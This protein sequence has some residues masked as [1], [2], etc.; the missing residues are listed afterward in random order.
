MAEEYLYEAELV[1]F[2]ERH[3]AV[4]YL[5]GDVTVLSGAGS[6]GW[7]CLAMTV[8]FQI[9]GGAV[10]VILADGREYRVADG[11]AF[12]LP[13]GLEHKIDRVSSGRLVSRWGDFRLVIFGRSDWVSQPALFSGRSAKRLGEIC[14]ALSEKPMDATELVTAAAQRKRWEFELLELIGARCV[15]AADLSADVAA[16]RRIGPALELM[17]QQMA[18]NLTLADLAGAVYL[19]PSRF[20]ALFHKALGV[21][22]LAHLQQ[23][24]LERACGLLLSSDLN[25][26]EVGH[27]VGYGDQFHFSRLFKRSYELSPQAYRKRWWGGLWGAIG[28]KKQ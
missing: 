27:A 17:R 3:L 16:L 25:I 5:G 6:T 4:E 15:V 28:E 24:R 23:M 22:P 21:A 26:A 10:E 18:A 20:H 19:S 2:V 9:T 8:C 12:V 1:A 14:A 13:A 7:R 11:E